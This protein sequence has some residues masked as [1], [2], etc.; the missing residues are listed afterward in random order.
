M[1]TQSISPYDWLKQIPASLLEKDQT[2]LIGYP[3]LFPWKEFSE[4]LGEI[5]EESSLSIVPIGNLEWREKA[6]L[7]DG[8]GSSPKA[9]S[10]T[11]APIGA[12]ICW[13]M[14]SQ[15]IALLI[16]LLL[17]RQAQLLDQIN[18]DFKQGF[19]TFLALEVVQAIAKIEF[20]STLSPHILD[21]EDLPKEDSLTLD[22]SI[23]LQQRTLWGRLCIKP[24]DLKKIR[25]YYAQQHTPS[26][27]N[28]K[29]SL[30]L[31]LEAGRASFTKSEWSQIGV[32]DFILLDKCS[33][34]SNKEGRILLTFNEI[35]LFRGKIKNGKIKILEYPLYY[36]DAHMDHEAEDDLHEKKH[37]GAGD[38]QED[39]DFDDEHD[40]DAELDE[41]GHDDSEED[42]ELD[43]DGHDDSEDDEELDEDDHSDDEDEV[44]DANGD[45]EPLNLDEEHSDDSEESEDFIDEDDQFL[46]EEIENPK[47]EK[48]PPPPEHHR[49][50]HAEKADAA[51]VGESEEEAVEP[52]EEKEEDNQTVALGEV[53][54]SIIIEV[55]R[56]EMSLQKLMELQPGN[57][58]DLNVRPENGVDLVVKG[59]RIAKGELLKVGETL[60]VRILDIG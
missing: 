57:L 52:E 53:P 58:L 48:W 41:D 45:D 32:G 31:H 24:A 4:V 16:S 1:T 13:V 60:G 26:T 36:E 46:D 17:T 25:E 59:R 30:P 27:L 8:L 12:E 56:I 49:E 43:E 9:I 20:D 47:E 33:L 40:H 3:P 5:F 28:Y 50:R 21:N 29:I 23:T 10:A 44:K 2:P 6:K 22:V 39:E 37:A 14:A 51:E 19:F 55:G 34:K 35:P 11:V 18:V 54:F 42:E 38:D 7:L 15:D